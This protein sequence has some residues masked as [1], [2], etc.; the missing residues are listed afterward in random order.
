MRLVCLSPSWWLKKVR[1]ANNKE[2]FELETFICFSLNISFHIK[3]FFV[4]TPTWWLKKS[5]QYQRIPLSL[6]HFYIFSLKQKRYL[7]IS[8]FSP[9]LL[10]LPTLILLPLSILVAQES[11]TSQY[12]KIHL[13]LKIFISFH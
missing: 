4:P 3:L 9:P 12:Q 5:G 10:I 1:Q 6:K 13:S 2:S 7:C 11:E 8:S